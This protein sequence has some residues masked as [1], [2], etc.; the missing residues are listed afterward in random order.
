MGFIGLAEVMPCYKA[1]GIAVAMSLTA[2]CEARA[3][4]L[5]PVLFRLTYFLASVR[6]L[7]HGTTQVSWW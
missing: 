1:L 5:K 2:T 4:Q 7:S 6:L 3:L